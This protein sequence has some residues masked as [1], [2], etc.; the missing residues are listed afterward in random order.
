MGEAE[1]EREREKLGV[2]AFTVDLGQYQI[3][4]CLDREVDEKNAD[5]ASPSRPGFLRSGRSSVR[6]KQREATGVRLACSKAFLIRC[7]QRD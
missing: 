6:T 2:A 3:S 4:S 7:A 5:S 1:R